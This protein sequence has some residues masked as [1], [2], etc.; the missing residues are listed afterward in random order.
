M[1]CRKLRHKNIVVLVG[2]VTDPEKLSIITGARTLPCRRQ[3]MQ[4]RLR[5]QNGCRAALCVTSC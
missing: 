1:R 4:E 2:I 3:L 5:L